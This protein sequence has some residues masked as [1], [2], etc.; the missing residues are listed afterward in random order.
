MLAY[1]QV[2]NDCRHINRDGIKK[3]GVGVLSPSL[4]TLLRSFSHDRKRVHVT[5][6][7]QF[8]SYISHAFETNISC[9]LLNRPLYIHIPDLQYTFRFRLRKSIASGDCTPLHLYKK[10]NKSSNIA[11]T[12]THFLSARQ[13]Q[14]DA[15]K[16]KTKYFTSF[17]LF[18]LELVSCF[19][20][21]L[22][23]NVA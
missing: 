4:F 8:I 6:S 20:K 23:D 12:I 17:H 11:I 5:A 3:C 14:L 21:F 22:S 10:N 9:G 13:I 18:P 15:H 19:R 1:D 7:L 2:S 16:I